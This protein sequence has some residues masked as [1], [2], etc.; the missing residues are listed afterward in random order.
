MLL[1]PNDTCPDCGE[2]VLR[3]ITAAGRRQFLDGEPDEKGNV[4]VYCDGP[5]TVRARVPNDDYPLMPW[6]RIYMP[7]QASC[8]NPQPRTIVPRPV[9][10]APSRTAGARSRSTYRRNRTQR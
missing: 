10:P 1:R 4:A 6:E 7:H 3:A 8:T 5:G 2:L 9:A